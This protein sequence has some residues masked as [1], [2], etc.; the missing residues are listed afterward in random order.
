MNKKQ[1]FE[2]IKGEAVAILCARY[3][4]RGVVAEVGDDGLLLA[5][6]ILVYETGNMSGDKAKSE[7]AC[8]TDTFISFDAIELMGQFPWAFQGLDCKTKR[9]GK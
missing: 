8:G 6:C 3:W 4:W 7:E 1:Y 2:K 9:E 5:D